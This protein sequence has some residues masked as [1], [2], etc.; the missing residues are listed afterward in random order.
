[1]PRVRPVG[2]RNPHDFQTRAFMRGHDFAHAGEHLLG[3]LSDRHAHV[4]L[5]PAIARQHVDL[6][7]TPHHPDIQREALDGVGCTLNMNAIDFC[8]RLF[9]A[10]STAPSMATGRSSIT[11]SSPAMRAAIRVALGLLCV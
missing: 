10:C 11:A 1:M 7:A 5:E 4:A 8:G 6:H 2:I 3:G 9:K